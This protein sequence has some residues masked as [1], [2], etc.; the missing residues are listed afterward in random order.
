MSASPPP[1]ESFAGS[2]QR[3]WRRLVKRAIDT[4]VAATVLVGGAPLLG[5]VAVGVWCSMGRPVLF[6]QDRPGLGGRP[7]RLVKFR[8]MRAAAPGEGVASD[9][10]RLTPF[11]RLLRSLSL[12]ELPQMVNVLK[13]DMSLV[14]PRPLLTQYLD[15]YTAEQA[16]RHDVLPGITGLAQI[17]GRNATTWEDRLR[18]DIAYVD[19]WSLSLDARIL[20]T[21]LWRVVKRE[22]VA[23]ANAATMPEFQGTTPSEPQAP[24][25]E[26]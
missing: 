6:T 9:G 21:T 5:A 13:G 18:H 26:R 10:A 12:D 2:R 19:A 23:N 7:F 3:G 25:S 4:S 8:T 1:P 15:R 11:G 14:G 16:R 22:G 24:L 20:W 17:N